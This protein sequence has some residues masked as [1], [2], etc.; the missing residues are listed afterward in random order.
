M[1]LKYLPAILLTLFPLI[2]GAVTV[3]VEAGQLE[4]LLQENPAAMTELTLRGSVNATDLHFIAMKMK[5]LKSLDLSAVK[6]EAVENPRLATNHSAYPAGQL[7]AYILS[8]TGLTSIT[9]PASLESIGDGALMSSAITA[10]TVP[11]TVR[12]I[13]RGAFADCKGLA[14]ITIPSTV[15]TVGSHAF[16]GCSALTTVS[17]GPKAVADCE[18]RGC[19]SLSDFSGSV[20]TVG[21]NAFAG[22]R[23]LREFPFT[24]K[25]RSI[26]EGAF[27]RSGLSEVTVVGS[28]L[29]AVGR[30]A[31][32]CCGDLVA[33]S[34]PSSVKTIGAGAF[35]DDAAMVMM[36]APGQSGKIEDFTFKGTS[37]MTD[38]YNLLNEGVDSIGRYSLA[39]MGSVTTLVMPSTLTYIGDHAMQNLPQLESIDAKALSSVPAL[40]NDVWAGV[41]Q[42]Q[43]TLYVDPMLENAFESTPQWNE[44]SIDTSGISTGIT[45]DTV[46]NASVK[47]SLDDDALKVESTL[48]LDRV[49]VYT[50]QGQLIELRDAAGV[51]SV[52]ISLEG[53]SERLLVVAVSVEGQ[54][55]IKAFKIAR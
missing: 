30:F 14:S 13:G 50:V 12:S 19:V 32:A 2:A 49:A 38:G 35:F 47:V 45:V 42:K 5:E 1:K 21:N 31:F 41:E 23:D 52:S 28:T 34:L 27:Y 39:D 53:R 46:D 43:V 4:S 3:D 22:C 40:G 11:P 24:D 18:F 10:V 26:G 20:E 9:L 8:G 17:Y 33:V 54:P 48:P 25:L 16:D 7:P 6:I 44:F 15:E 55:D 37:S 51:N 36:S 29:T